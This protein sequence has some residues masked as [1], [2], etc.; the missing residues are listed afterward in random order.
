MRQPAFDVGPNADQND[1]PLNRA[2]VIH[3]RDPEAMR[4]AMLSVY[5]AREFTAEAEG[6]EGFGSYVAF[7]AA[8][9]GFCAYAAPAAAEFGETDFARV[10]IA[11]R[12]SSRTSAGASSVD[13]DPQHWCVSSAAT[14]T[15]IEFG[16]DYQQVILRI[17]DATLTATLEALLGV[18]PRGRLTFQPDLP[19]DRA[20][21]GA[22]R[23]LMI[24]A[25]RHVDPAAPALPPLMLREIQQALVVSFLSVARHNYSGQLDRDAPDTAPDYVR[26]AEEFIEASW[27][28]AITIV[29]LAAVTNVGVRSLFKAFQKHRGYSPMAFAK[30]VRL[31][32]AREL[33]LSGEPSRS[34]TAVAF[35]CG[36][37]NLGHFANDYR[38][39]HGELP[40]ETL[41]RRR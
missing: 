15:R 3:T 38:R 5:G 12:G 19:G 21:A 33:L 24:Y 32:K 17:P 39:R 23:D 6:F 34:V 20:G 36:F 37:T 40:S 1:Y 16:A 13:L 11:L 27:N 41:A 25:A 10:Q 35:A 30:A 14:P 31:N 26:V 29:D 2:P 9:L 22:L 4:E 7:E 8:G 18:K 28:R